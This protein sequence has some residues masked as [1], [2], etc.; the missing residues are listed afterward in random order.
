LKIVG[1][2]RYPAELTQAILAFPAAE[3]HHGRVASRIDGLAIKDGEKE[4]DGERGTG[5]I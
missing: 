2:R 1:K 5:L 3:R 4:T